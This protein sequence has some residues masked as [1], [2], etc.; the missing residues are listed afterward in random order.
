MESNQRAAAQWALAV[1]ALGVVFGD[2]GTSPLYTVQTVFNPGD[3]H[4]VTVS[5][6]SI[7]G[8]VSLIFWSVTT[9]VTLT[10]VVLVMR[11]DNDGEGGVMALIALI[12]RRGVRGGRRTAAMLSALGIFGASLFFGDSM[13]TPAISVLSAIEGVKVAAPPAA[14]LVIPITVVIIVGL[15]GVQRLGTGAVGRLFGPVMIFWF[16]VVGALGVRGV[17]GHPAIL[18]ALSP[19]YAL[20]FLFGH[21]GTAFF[22]LTAVVLAVTGAEALYADM[23]HFGRGPVRRGWLLLV[24]PAL[25]LNYMGQGALILGDRASVANPFFLLA[26]GWARLPMVFLAAVATVIASQAVITGAY[27]VAHQAARLGYLPRLR[28]RYTSEEQVG[29]IYVPWINWLLLVA[30]LTLVLTFRSSASLAYAYGT[31]VTGTITITTLLFFYVARTH[32]HWRRWAVLA[33]GGTLIAIDLLFFAANLTKLVHGA[34]LPLLIGLAAFTVFTT[35]QRGRELVTVQRDHEE[36][37]LRTFVDQL[38]AMKPPLPRVPGTAVFLNRGKATAPLALRANVEHN[39]ILHRNVL[40]LAVETVPV[41]HV[42]PGERITVDDLGYTDD[43]IFH[44]TARFG[45]MDPTSIPGLLPL[46]RE[47][48]AEGAVHDEGLSYFLSHIE[49]VPGH[50]PG[51]SRWRKRLFIATSRI[52]ADAAE[53]FQLPRDKTLIVGSRIEL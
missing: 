21:F 2:I 3:P 20:G 11:A 31:A 15:F 6:Q 45:Y 13:I 8:I 4:P 28:I 5:T 16:V 26:P 35:W 9:V 49:I 53:Y 37:P 43:Q 40:I 24:F 39:H 44:V 36:G 46:I 34:W 32:W 50:S 51:M 52:T 19:T 38:H 22:S 7:F 1:G 33:G 30:V 27:S 42:P 14:D 29:Q 23:G 17:A 18:K 41:P 25:T 47:A 12:R 10:Y 48:G